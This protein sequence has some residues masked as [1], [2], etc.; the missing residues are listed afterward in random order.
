MRRAL[1]IA[2]LGML[3]TSVAPALP[4]ARAAQAQALPAGNVAAEQRKLLAAI[5]K[6]LI[7]DNHGHPGRAGDPD[8]D[9]MPAIPGSAPLRL[10]PGNPE[11]VA[12]ARALWGY[13]F[14]DLSPQHA[15]WLTARKREL[16]QR[17]GRGYFSQVLDR[18][19]IETAIANRVRMPDYLDPQR[20]RWVFFV[21]SFLFPFHTQAYAAGNPDVAAYLPAQTKLLQ[22][23]LGG[24]P[25][26]KMPATLE[27]YEQAV[28]RILRQEQAAGAVGMK[29]EIAYFRPLQ[30]SDPPRGTA[31]ALYARWARGGVPLRREYLEFQDYMFRFLLREAAALH[32]P[33][34]IHTAVGT[35]DYYSVSGGAVLRLE[36]ILRDPRYSGVTFVLLHGGYPFERQAIWLTARAN[37]YLDSSLMEFYLYPAALARVLRQWLELFPDKIVFGSDAYPFDPAIGAEEAYWLGVHSA[38]EALATALAGM[39]EDGEV[40]EARA[41][42]LA[43][44]FL[45]DNAKRLYQGK[46]GLGARD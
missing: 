39:V 8:V 2:V 44:G 33:V 38:R 4:R 32:W 40:S 37:V 26:P 22:Q 7:F 27:A 21:D 19:G 30:F 10:R 31:A 3:M 11:W 5:D 16:Q 14:G 6:I 18:V 36:P 46:K 24:A 15:A 13:P 41:L 43:H 35:G 42:E 29:F 20:F 23:W 17:E 34:Q 12:A 1:A 25:Q 9:A 45:H 28:D